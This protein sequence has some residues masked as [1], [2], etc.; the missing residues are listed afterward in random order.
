MGA[1]ESR[2]EITKKVYFYAFGRRAARQQP[3]PGINSSAVER[4]NISG[5]FDILFERR[6]P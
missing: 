2:N 3:F 5:N 4:V 1:I 6:F